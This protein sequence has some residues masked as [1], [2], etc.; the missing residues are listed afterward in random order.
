[1]YP[2]SL[3]RDT[4]YLRTVPNVSNNGGNSCSGC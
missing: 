4:T 2:Y 3:L 1:M